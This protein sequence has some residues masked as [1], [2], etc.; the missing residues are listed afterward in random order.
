MID[1]EML[2]NGNVK[3][4]IP[5]SFRNCSFPIHSMKIWRMV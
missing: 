4:T 2:A 3:V 1:V 5:M